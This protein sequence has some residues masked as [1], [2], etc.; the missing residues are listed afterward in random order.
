[1]A[2]PRDYEQRDKGYAEQE[3]T[4][5]ATLGAGKDGKY[6]T[7]VEQLKS[8][9]PMFKFPKEGVV[10]TIDPT[11]GNMEAL[12]T[13]TGRRAENQGTVRCC[14]A[15]IDSAVANEVKEKPEC[16]A[17]VNCD[18][19]TGLRCSPKAFN[20]AFSNP[21][22]I[23]VGTEDGNENRAEQRVLD[24]LAASSKDGILNFGGVLVLVV[25]YAFFTMRATQRFLM[26]HFEK[27]A[28]WKFRSD[29]Y[30][31][32]QQVV[33]VGRRTK[34][35][36]HLFKDELDAEMALYDSEDK[37]EELPVELPEELKGSVGI[38]PQE[39]GALEV[40][41]PKKFDFLGNAAYL[42]S[43]PLA[44]DAARFVSGY[45]TQK[46]PA[47]INMDKPYPILPGKG[48]LQT[49]AAI[50]VGNGLMGTPGED[51]II[52]EGVVEKATLKEYISNPRDPETVAVKE[53]EV[54]KTYV[55]VTE[56]FRDEHGRQRCLISRVE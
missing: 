30:E 33:Y 17:V 11:C 42:D 37:L 47:A 35:R 6:Y 43:H 24:V 28:V 19:T 16:F 15:E 44:R 41:A 3:R 10:Y 45:L 52:S 12:F 26:N 55:N 56:I 36:D 48:V 20:F 14:G 13:V 25:N 34:L 22:Y 31:K 1:M 8:L 49:D 46:M 27:I 54:S 40:F 2:M 21:P 18:V 29:E 5:L 50:G 32:F 23:N 51:Q 4:N 9:A 39:E 38:A 7:S 53:T